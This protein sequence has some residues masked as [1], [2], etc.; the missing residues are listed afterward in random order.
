[1]AATAQAPGGAAD[2][3]ATVQ[4]YFE[5]FLLDFVEPTGDEAA[6]D[7]GGAAALAAGEEEARPYVEQFHAMKETERT[8]LFVDFQHLA[9]HD[10]ELSDAIKEQFHYLEPHLRVGIVCG[11]LE[12]LVRISQ[13]VMPATGKSCREGAEPMI[14]GGQSTLEQLRA[15]RLGGC[16][17]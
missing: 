10:S 8:T 2:F 5:T 7:E 6:A 11:Q 9:S 12:Q 1:M 13:P 3:V 17:K 15:G 14:V 16:A 4:S